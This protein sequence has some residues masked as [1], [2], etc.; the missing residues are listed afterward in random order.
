MAM[1]PS[2]EGRKL[3]DD[4]AKQKVEQKGVSKTVGIALALSRQASP[5][6]MGVFPNNN[7]DLRPDAYRYCSFPGWQS[8][9]SAML[10]HVT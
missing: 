7:G 4:I 9:A 3:V 2:E 6:F 1:L 10:R 8:F 5:G